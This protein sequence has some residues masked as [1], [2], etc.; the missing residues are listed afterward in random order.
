MEGKGGNINF[1]YFPFSREGESLYVRESRK[2]EV[3]DGEDNSR[4]ATRYHAGLTQNTLHAKVLCLRKL[5]GS[6]K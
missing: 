6:F 5:S 3:V 4:D 1:K 2:H